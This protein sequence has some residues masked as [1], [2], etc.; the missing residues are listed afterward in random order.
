MMAIFGAT[1]HA[2]PR[3]KGR[4]TRHRVKKKSPDKR[5]GVPLRL[6][7][8][9]RRFA[10]GRSYVT[11]LRHIGA[12]VQSITD[13]LLSQA[14]AAGAPLDQTEVDETL[15][16]AGVT[17]AQAK[18]V[19]RALTDAGVLDA[20]SRRRVV[21]AR[22][23]TAASGARATTVKAAAKPA[24]ENA[25][26]PKAAKSS[27]SNRGT[28]RLA[29]VGTLAPEVVA[30]VTQA[31]EGAGAA[32]KKTT[33]AAGSKKATPEPSKTPKAAE[34]TKTGQAAKAGTTAKA[35]AGAK[36]AETMAA[37]RAKAAETVA[38]PP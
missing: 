13:A 14:A 30:E 23:A 26:P 6:P 22:S 16:G 21:A 3:V 24:R 33:R 34:T 12:D 28:A 37:P 4:G 29:A 35:G 2:C 25:P 27:R 11:E 31:L 19:V 18:K 1:I 10:T 17:S 15:E 7:K 32:S 36:A 9:I 5:R 38:A 8:P 20:G